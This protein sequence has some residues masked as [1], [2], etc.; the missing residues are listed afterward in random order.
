M[1]NKKQSRI[2]RHKRVR[3]VVKGTL[4]R[5]R[6]SVF[7]SLAAI[8]VQLIDDEAGKTLI[9]CSSAD[10]KSKGKKQEVAFEVGKLAAQKAMDKNIKEVVFDRGG[11]KYHGR[12]KQCADGARSGGLKF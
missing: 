11:Y 9:A 5:P 7:R 2:M 12:V 3:A 8:Y 1:N 6:M 10:I 4:T